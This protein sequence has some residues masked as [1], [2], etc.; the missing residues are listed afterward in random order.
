MKRNATLFLLNKHARCLACLFN[1][2]HFCFMVADV[3]R[4]WNSL[5]QNIKDIWEF[6]REVKGLSAA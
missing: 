3:G 5:V 4:D 1:I 6:M 2:S